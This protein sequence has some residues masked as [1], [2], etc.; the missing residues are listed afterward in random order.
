V[1]DDA[2]DSDHICIT[3]KSREQEPP[4]AFDSGVLMLGLHLHILPQI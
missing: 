3:G 2:T 1:V 4:F